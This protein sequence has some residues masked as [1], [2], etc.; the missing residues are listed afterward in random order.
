[1]K[2]FKRINRWFKDRS[3]EY[4]RVAMHGH[5]LWICRLGHHSWNYRIWEM[6]SQK[7]CERCIQFFDW[8][9]KHKKWINTNN[10]GLLYKYKLIDDLFFSMKE[11][12][13]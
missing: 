2:L 3:K 5:H 12:I 10:G 11:T 8:D 1:M 13:S 6:K 7:Y 4:N 9:N